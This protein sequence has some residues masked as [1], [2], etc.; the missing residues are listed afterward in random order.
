[1]KEINI[2][3]YLYDAGGNDEEVELKD[4][5]LKKLTDKQ[6][7]WVNILKRDEKLIKETAAKLQIENV[8]LKS[9]LRTDERPKIEQFENFYRIFIASAEVKKSRKF[10]RVPI[11]FLVGKNFIVTIHDGDVEYFI[12][13]RE[14][15]KGETRIGVLNAESFLISLLDLHILSYFQ[16]LENI[17]DKVDKFDE[18]ILKENLETTDFLL[19]M[20]NLR[21]DVSNLRRWLTPHRD[22][23]YALSRPDFLPEDKS[24]SVENFRLL[25]QHFD[26]VMDAIETSRDTVL[27]LFDLYAARAAHKL[28]FIVQRLTFLTLM[29]GAMGVVAGILGMNFELPFFKN[30]N[31]FWLVILTMGILSITFTITARWRRWI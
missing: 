29:I 20:V 17:A 19:E 12:G 8:P 1:M 14:R 24:G 28:N 3:A 15:E 16:A 9:I 18:R 4:I 26:N 27:S 11:D 2:Y 23:F 5:E 22:V 31:G 30:P 7:L 13:F 21:L 6:L 10:A 25:N